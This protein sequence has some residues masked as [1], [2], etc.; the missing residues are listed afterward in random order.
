LTRCW[1]PLERGRFLLREWDDEF[2]I[3]NA[4]TATTHLLDPVAAALVL[5]L[6]EAQGPLTLGEL[7]AMLLSHD[8]ANKLSNESP[9]IPAL[10]ELERIGVAD[11]SES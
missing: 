9:L 1:H 6:R 5:T 2:V 3:Y 7:D 8:P 11:S 4:D 10:A